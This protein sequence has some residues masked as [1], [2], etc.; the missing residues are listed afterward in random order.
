MHEP[1]RD[2]TATLLRRIDDLE[3]ENRKLRARRRA[4][5]RRDVMGL[6][7][8]ACRMV[9][10]VVCAGGILAV[11]FTIVGCFLVIVT[12]VMLRG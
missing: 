3:R 4:G 9:G 10:I 12:G 5:F 1:F 6:V 8:T 11:A 2:A 7:W